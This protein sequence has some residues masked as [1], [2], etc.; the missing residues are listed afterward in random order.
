MDLLL[1]S[2]LANAR[3][4]GARYFDLGISTDQ[5]GT[6]I[7]NGL[8]QY[9]SEFGGGAAVHEFYMIHLN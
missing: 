9:K 5:A 4:S 2:S 1:E 7:N 6:V 8:F 3:E